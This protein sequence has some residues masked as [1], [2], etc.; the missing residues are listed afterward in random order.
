MHE[1]VHKWNRIIYD[2]SYGEGLKAEY[3]WER[4]QIKSWPLFEKAC[5]SHVPASWKATIDNMLDRLKPYNL[6]IAQIKE[7]FCML[8][9]YHN[10]Y[11]NK[12]V[13]AIIEDARNELRDLG[14]HPPQDFMDQ[15]TPL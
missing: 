13:A 9:V 11:D 6:E 14:V 4:H 10:Q 12:E 2:D 7:K 1:Q 5:S 3:L 15:P 8:T